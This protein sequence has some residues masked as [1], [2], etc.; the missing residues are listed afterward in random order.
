MCVTLNTVTAFHIKAVSYNISYDRRVLFAVKKQPP[1]TKNESDWAKKRQ[2]KY[3][4][5]SGKALLVSRR[6]ATPVRSLH[7][8][9]LC[10]C[11]GVVLLLL[12]TSCSWHKLSVYFAFTVLDTSVSMYPHVGH[13]YCVLSNCSIYLLMFSCMVSTLHVS[14]TNI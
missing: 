5:W 13:F 3:I 1:D 2:V 8:G 11:L 4:L 12:A 7:P 9:F 14:L 10:G 6:K